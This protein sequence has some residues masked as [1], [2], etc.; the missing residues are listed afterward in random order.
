MLREIRHPPALPPAE[1]PLT[2]REIEV[3]QLIA[4]GLSNQ[5]VGDS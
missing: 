5:E 3:L 4:Q 2:E 1:Q